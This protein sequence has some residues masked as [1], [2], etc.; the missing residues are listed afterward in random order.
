[1]AVAV[2]RRH[3]MVWAVFAPKLVFDAALHAAHAAAL[4]FAAWASSD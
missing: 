2:H 4:L 1:M 3:L